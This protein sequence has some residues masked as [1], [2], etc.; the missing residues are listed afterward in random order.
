MEVLRD[1]YIATMTHQ[2]IDR[3]MFVELF[4]PLVGLED[5]WRQQGAS[6]DE[7]SLTAFGFDTVRWEAA[8]CD[9]G[10]MGG[11]AVV[12]LEDNDEF[13]IRRDRFGRRCKLCKAA[14]TIALPMEYP[15]TDMDSWLKLKPMYEFA[16]DRLP[17]GWDAPHDPEALVVAF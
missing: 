17:D 13:Q 14:A 7:I 6:E 15:V 4:G 10:M 2:P 8:R 16:E 11:D 3:P 5:E 9:T 1:Q 12:V